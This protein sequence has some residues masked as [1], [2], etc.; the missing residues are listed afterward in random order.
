[1]SK[2]IFTCKNCGKVFG[3]YYYRKRKYCSRKCRAN[4]KEHLNKSIKTIKKVDVRGKNNPMYGKPLV[5]WNKDK[6]GYKIHSEE[7]REKK[8]NQMK[9]NKHWNWQGG[10]SKRRQGYYSYE[11]KEWRM[12]VFLRDNFTCQFCGE[13][14]NYKEAHHIKSFAKHSEL[15]FDLNN[16]VTLCKDCHNLTK[17]GRGNG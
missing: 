10:K 12:A 3:D 15:R 14:G 13:R 8:S 11:Y 1:M 4:S 16:G 2:T 6:K 17:R 9:G 5:P 7:W